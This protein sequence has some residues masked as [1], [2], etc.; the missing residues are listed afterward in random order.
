MPPAR[1]ASTQLAEFAARGVSNSDSFSA[2][3]LPR[4]AA[5]LAP[6]TG[7]GDMELRVRVGFREGP[8]GFPEIRLQMAGQ[9]RLICQRCLT[10]M[11]WGLDADVTLTVTAAESETAELSSPFDSVALEDGTLDLPRVIED[12]ILATLPLAPMHSAAGECARMLGKHAPGIAERAE[13][14]RPFA[15][16]GT[17]IGRNRKAD[18]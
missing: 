1:I 15:D 17:L 4:L 16:L 13:V 12:E 3:D 8:E 2:H 9:L 14:H 5:I 7:Q 18:E 6:R 11:P 10:P